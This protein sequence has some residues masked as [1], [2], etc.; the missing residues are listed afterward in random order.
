MLKT[1]KIIVSPLD[2]GIGHATRVVPIIELL[3]KQ[4]WQVILAT[5]GRSAEFL[6]K[7]YPN[8]PCYTPPDYAIRYSLQR[9]MQQQMLRHSLRFLSIIKQEQRW[10]QS[11]VEK[12]NVSVVISDNRFGMHAK[13]CFNI[14]ITHQLT[15]DTG[16]QTWLE[17]LIKKI[18]ATFINRFNEVWVPDF[19]PPN[20]FCGKLT[21]PS[22]KIKQKIHYIGFQSRLVAPEIKINNE[23]HILAIVSGPEPQRTAFE[24]LLIKQLSQSTEKCIIIRGKTESNTSIQVSSNITLLSHIK[25]YQLFTSLIENS[26]FIISRGGFS[27]LMDCSPF[28]KKHVIVPTPGQTEQHYL[29]QQLKERNQAIYY[30]QEKFDFTDASLK[31]DRIA[32]F[33][34]PFNKNEDLVQI[35][36][37]LTMKITRQ[38]T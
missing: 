32:P 37:Q 20:N 23:R 15:I 13:G 25:D 35:I 4:N 14:F 6:S 29:A 36:D 10:L 24:K 7:A 26:K 22:S 1:K 27:T 31:I 9:S 18:N 2:W 8:L 16:K 3:L 19:K 38:N 30:T 11:L 12:E 33:Y 17:P 5:N 21:I 34:I 28:S